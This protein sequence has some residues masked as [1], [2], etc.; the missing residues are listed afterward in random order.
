MVVVPKKIIFLY[1]FLPIA[2]IEIFRY[3]ILNIAIIKDIV[4]NTFLSDD[5]IIFI[6]YFLSWIISMFLLYIRVFN[7]IGG[8]SIDLH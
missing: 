8:D 1:L 6:F 3:Q 7:S 2:I 4:L 5:G